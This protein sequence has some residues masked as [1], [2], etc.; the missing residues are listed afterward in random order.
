MLTSGYWLIL[1][2]AE[3]VLFGQNEILDVVDLVLGAAV[4]GEQHL[5][6][7]LDVHRHAPAIV[8]QAAL[9]DRQDGAFHW[10]LFA[11]RVGQENPALG[12]LLAIRRL[13]YHAVSQR[14]NAKVSCHNRC[15]F[16][17]LEPNSMRGRE[18]AMIV[19]AHGP[20][21]PHPVNGI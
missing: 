4:L 1:N 12:L 20:T 5:V 9:A 7:G 11:G 21:R 6:A 13:D 18:H 17:I 10:A 3:N 14:P 2:D 16:L 19:S 15:P 8:V